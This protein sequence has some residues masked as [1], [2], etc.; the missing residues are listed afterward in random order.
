MAIYACENEWCCDLVLQVSEGLPTKE[1]V[2]SRV[3][4]AHQGLV[5]EEGMSSTIYEPCE[6]GGL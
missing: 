6:G 2:E 5:E 1:H 3:Y 4:C